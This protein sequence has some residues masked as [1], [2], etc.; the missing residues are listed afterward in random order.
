MVLLSKNVKWIIIM[1][2][3][4]F[5]ATVALAVEKPPASGKVALVNGTVITQRE[6]DNE[7]SQIKLRIAQRGQDLPDAQ[8]QEFRKKV[9]DSLVDKELLYQES[10]RE[11]II[12]EEKFIE[13]HLAS[14]KQ[15]FPNESEYKKTLEA[16]NLSESSLR[17]K[18]EK[19]Y[20]VQKLI[21]KQIVDGV[22]ISGN[23]SQSFYKGNPELFKQPEQVRASHILVKLDANANDQQ[24]ADARKKIED[25]QRQLKQ[26]QGFSELATKFSEGPSSAKGGDL[27]FFRRGQMVKPFEEVAFG[28]KPG[29]VSGVVETQFGYHIIKV[30]DRKPEHMVKFEEVEA[31]ITQHL[32]QEKVRQGVYQYIQKLKESAKIEKF[33]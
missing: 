22:K 32:K 16:L 14:Q 33:I 10:Q 27:G 13:D 31:K 3:L 23:D 8:L 29:E 12:V 4:L 7:V 2:A 19:E 28:L 15:K 17:S 24:R 30:I 25:I 26:G 9:L 6:F 5:M 18:I 20:A 11:G 21:E 1:T